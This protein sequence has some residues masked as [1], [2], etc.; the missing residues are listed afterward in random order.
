MSIMRDLRQPAFPATGL[1]L[2]LVVA[3][4][5]TGA[6]ASPT[7]PVTASPTTAPA[8]ATSAPTATATPAATPAETPAAAASGAGG[9]GRYGGGHTATPAPVGVIVIHVT[10]TS[11]GAVLFGPDDHALYTSSSDSTDKSTCAGGCLAAWPPLLV[12]AGGTVKGAAGVTGE[13]SWFKRSD[14]THQ[15][16]YKGLPLYYFA[17]DGQGTVSGDGLGGFYA[18]T[19]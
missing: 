15:V 1:L 18:A 4:C 7:P 13:V 11:G 3:A 19:P 12:P 16:T 5:S 8:T 10:M 2:V 6:A 14:G 17:S 9:G